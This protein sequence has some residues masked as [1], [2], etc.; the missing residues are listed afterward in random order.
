MESNDNVV[1]KPSE[2]TIV[3]ESQQVS[4]EEQHTPATRSEN[5]TED[6]TS[7][8]RSV[9]PLLRS[10]PRIR[11]PRHGGSR[12]HQAS[13][14]QEKVPQ[15]PTPVPVPSASPSLEEIHPGLH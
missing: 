2:V 3:P 8:E 10:P 1:E 14:G 5:K 15:Q 11:L 7:T 6:A 13:L 12:Q 4:I 9:P